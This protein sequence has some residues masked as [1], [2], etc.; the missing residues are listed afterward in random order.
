[1]R[2]HAQPARDG[3]SR[4]RPVALISAAF[5]LAAVTGGIAYASIPDASHT[6]TACMLKNV[7]TLRLIDTSLSAGNPLGHCTAI[8]TQISWNATAQQGLP[9]VAGPPGPKGDAG[10]QGPE[11]PKGDPG[12]GSPLLANVS[13]HGDLVSGNATSIDH[14][15][16]GFYIVSFPREV[17]TCVPEVTIGSNPGLSFGSATVAYASLFSG[18]NA[19]AVSVQRPVSPYESV[20][21]SFHLAVFCP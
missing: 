6:F 9:G 20:D 18:S 14:P 8:E 3:R 21:D 11:G 5:G 7:G 12:S 1:M 17:D 16:D 19:V 10:P 13:L 4:K 15:Q 2:A